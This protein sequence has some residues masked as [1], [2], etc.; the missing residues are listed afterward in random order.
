MAEYDYNL[1]D[2]VVTNYTD[3]QLQ[4]FPNYHT[5]IKIGGQTLIMYI[6]YNS[7]NKMRSITLNTLDGFTLLPF[8]FV[9]EGRRCE[10]NR[11]AELEG[12]NYY[13]TL[14]QTNLGKVIDKEYD[15]LNWSSD[16]TLCFVGFDYSLIERMQINL[17]ISLTGD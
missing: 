16:F 4:N 7:R 8:T 5:T 10:L 14:R 1:I 9:T 15:Y 11:I 17:R 13:V 2:D 12:F 3:I 6:K